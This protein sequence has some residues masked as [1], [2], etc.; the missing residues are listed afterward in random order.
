MERK[1]T[2]SIILQAISMGYEFDNL[3]EKNLWEFFFENE[4]LLEQLEDECEVTSTNRGQ[5]VT[6]GDYVCR[7][8]I[9][10][11]SENWSKPI[12]TKVYHSNYLTIDRDGLV[13]NMNLYYIVGETEYNAPAGCYYDTDRE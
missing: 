9:V 6:H 7:G 13:K 5:L 2:N 3:D 11:F 1:I 4:D 8:E 10:Q 12:G